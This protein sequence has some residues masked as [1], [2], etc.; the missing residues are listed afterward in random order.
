MTENEIFTLIPAYKPEDGL[1]VLVDELITLG[2]KDVV[3]VD[4]G[5]G[6]E[7]A[8][9]FEHLRQFEQVSVLVHAENQG[10]GAALKTGFKYIYER[11]PGCKVVVTADA[12]GQHTAVDILNIAKCSLENPDALVLG[13]RQFDQMLPKSRFGNTITHWIFRLVFQLKIADTQTGLRGV[14]RQFIPA[15]LYIPYNRYEYETE[16]ILI[17]KR[18]NVPI[19]ELPIQTIYLDGNK[20]SHFNILV[21]SAKIYFILFRY[22]AASLI[23]ALVDYIVFY[24]LFQL[25]GSVLLSMVGSRLV[26]LL[27]N[28]LIL[29]TR[30][31]YSQKN[32]LVTFV[33][34]VA[35]VI[36]SGILAV[37]GINFLSFAAGMSVIMAK[38]VAETAI[39]FL[40]FFA[41]TYLVFGLK[42]SGR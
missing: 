31:Y 42:R 41:N 40:N 18:E 27:V 9:R 36:F 10:K 25:N 8:H 29:N 7:F 11:F 2:I 15:C 4:D 16:M 14:S 6:P 38:L 17:T 19:V 21:D 26:S 1:L 34:Y 35:L 12:D 28:F 37:Q 3:V 22:T 5:S 30:V 32:S 33:K 13:S 20:S 24:I 23:S 39:Y